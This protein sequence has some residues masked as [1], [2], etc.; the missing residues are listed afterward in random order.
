MLDAVEG[1]SEPDIVDL[2]S[3]NLREM[4]QQAFQRHLFWYTNL[5]ARPTFFYNC[6]IHYT[7]LVFHSPGLKNNSGVSHY[8]LLKMLAIFD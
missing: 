3:V 1:L 4:T 2:N 5:V 6:T 7:P 8:F